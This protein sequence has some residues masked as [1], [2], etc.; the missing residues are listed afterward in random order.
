MR[1]HRRVDTDGVVIESDE[2]FSGDEQDSCEDPADSSDKSCNDDESAA[3]G[4]FIDDEEVN[5]MR[6]AH[7]DDE[8]DEESNLSESSHQSG[9]SSTKVFYHLNRCL[10]FYN[11]R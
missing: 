10:L 1:N 5:S 2:W 8:S 3:N 4:S 9:T 11:V 6:S 7:D